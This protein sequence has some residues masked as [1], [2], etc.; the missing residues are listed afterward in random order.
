MNLRRS[1]HV[2]GREVRLSPRSPTVFFAIAIPLLMTFLFSAVFGTLWEA[3]PRLGIVDEDASQVTIA[4]QELSGVDVTIV[5]GEPTLRRMVEDHDL[6]AG[7]VLPARFDEAIANVREAVELAP[8]NSFR[9]F[10]A[11]QVHALAG[12][13]EATYRYLEE[14]LAAGFSREE[15][16]RDLCFEALR[17]EPEFRALL[18]SE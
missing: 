8:G 14:A 7:L 2:F 6:D 4:A 15:I 5:D 17:D 12:D 13:A 18:A 11:A 3:P 16:G 9:R 1:F 10:N